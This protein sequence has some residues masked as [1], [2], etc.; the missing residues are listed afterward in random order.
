MEVDDGASASADTT[1]ME[2]ILEI[3]AG[4]CADDLP[5]DARM[6]TWSESEVQAYFES[7][8]QQCPPAV[9]SLPEKEPAAE[10]AAPPVGAPAQVTPPLA[11]V[12]GHRSP[13]GTWRKAAGAAPGSA[14][15]WSVKAREPTREMLPPAATDVLSARERAAVQVEVAALKKEG[16]EH[17]KAQRLERAVECYTAALER[18][19]GASD[20]AVLLA[21]RALAHLRARRHGAAISDCDASLALTPSYAKAL[22]RRAQACEALGQLQGARDD[23]RALLEC[24]PDNGDGRSMARRLDARIER[25]EGRLATSVGELFLRC[26]WCVRGRARVC[27]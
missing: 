15:V 2:R 21:N 26:V 23:A 4:C 12:L 24:E 7:G 16:N 18:G 9:A 11:Q 22:Y 25:Q 19:A 20:A 5:V 27:E 1:P 14:A 10:P 6:C 8:G 13:T 17:V 3:Q